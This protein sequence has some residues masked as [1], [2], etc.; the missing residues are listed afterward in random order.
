MT[1]PELVE[2]C[3]DERQAHYLSTKLPYRDLSEEQLIEH[4]AALMV[5]VAE[6][7]VRAAVLEC[8]GERRDDKRSIRGTYPRMY[9]GNGQAVARALPENERVPDGRRLP[10]VSQ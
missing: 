7:R 4:V 1:C 8:R 5:R 3:G 2:F 10:G 6:R 9:C